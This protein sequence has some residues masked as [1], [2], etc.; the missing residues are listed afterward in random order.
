VTEDELERLPLLDWM[1]SRIP[2]RDALVTL[3][4]PGGGEFPKEKIPAS[5]EQRWFPLDDGGLRLLVPYNGQAFD[6]KLFHIEPDAWDHT[7]CDVCIK[8]IRPMTLC[9]VTKFDP[10]IEL[11]VEC[12]A[13][14][15]VKRRGLLNLALWHAKRLIG[16]D[17]P[18]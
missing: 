15:V 9:Y 4:P 5:P 7:T 3:V 13:T 14:H 11:C 16:I 6:L 10:Y 18:V 2:L 1:P 17:G 8:R 12:Y